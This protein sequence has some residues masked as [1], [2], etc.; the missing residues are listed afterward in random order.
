[1]T[2]CLHIRGIGVVF[3]VLRES[4]NPAWKWLIFWVDHVELNYDINNYSMFSLHQ[5]TSV[6][7]RN[8]ASVTIQN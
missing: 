8:Y 7:Y 6:C 5:N 4:I 2:I 3:Q 1:M